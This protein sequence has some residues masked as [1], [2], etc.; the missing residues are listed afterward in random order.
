VKKANKSLNAAANHF[1]LALCEDNR[2][3]FWGD[4]ESPE[5][6]EVT[7]DLVQKGQTMFYIAITPHHGTH[8]HD[9]LH[10]LSFT[11]AISSN[12][13]KLISKTKPFKE[14]SSKVRSTFIN[15]NVSIAI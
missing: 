7:C 5:I 2:F 12:G 10:D 3:I 13:D 11:Y 4:L 6:R 14:V 9:N 15:G 1:S 8:W